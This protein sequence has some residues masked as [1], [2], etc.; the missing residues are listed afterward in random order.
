[1]KSLIAIICV[2]LVLVVLVVVTGGLHTWEYDTNIGGVSYSKS[3]FEE[4]SGQGRVLIG[5]LKHPV[6][7][8]G[9]RYKGWLHRRDNQTIGGGLLAEA[10][11]INGLPIPAE[12]WVAF[13]EN[14][15][16]SACHFP[17]NQTIQEHVCLGTGGGIKGATVTFYPS[18][19]LKVFFSP[20]DIKV[21][22]IPCRGGLFTTIELQESGQLRSCTI[23]Q[24]AVI[25]GREYKRG[26]KFQQ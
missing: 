5:H 20:T 4:I 13:D 10:T 15:H 17:A 23:S 25:N 22:D 1:M 8:A 26:A 18:G 7:I 12:T 2:V 3:R 24:D 9:R 6:E 21:N 16:L 14:G 19:R 11:N